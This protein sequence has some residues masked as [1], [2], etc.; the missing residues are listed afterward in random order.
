MGPFQIFPP[1]SPDIETQASRIPIRK[2]KKPAPGVGSSSSISSIPLQEIKSSNE[3][4]TRRVREEDVK[5]QPPRKVHVKSHS[6]S[7]LG[8][9]P[10]P[11]W[12]LRSV[13][14]DD[15]AS[16]SSS[17]LA[18]NSSTQI[19]PA[20]APVPS[21]SS[22]DIPFIQQPY[23]QQPSTSRLPPFRHKPLPPR[24]LPPRPRPRGLTLSPEPEIDRDLG[25][26]TVPASVMNFPAGIRES[27]EMRDSSTA[28]L[29]ELWDVANG[30]RMEGGLGRFCLRLVRYGY[31]CHCFRMVDTDATRTGI[32]TFTLGNTQH[33]FYTISI[34]TNTNNKP[35]FLSISR[36]NPSNPQINIPIMSLALE[37]HDYQSRNDNPITHLFS[38]LAAM[39]AIEQSA[40]LATQHNL[41]SADALD[42]EGKAL[43][44]AVEMES[45]QLVWVRERAGYELVHPSLMQQQQQQ[46]QQRVQGQG[47]GQGQTALVG[48]AGIALSPAPALSPSPSPS[49]SSTRPNPQNPGPLHITVSTP[50]PDTSTEEHQIGRA[51]V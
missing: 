13:N 17:S 43:R 23:Y 2:G 36:T 14:H 35:T 7:G 51:H 39:L 40:E 45:C 44:R 47:Q 5:I 9:Q 48:A 25:P 12:T 1:P 19:P 38:H 41:S 29:R 31:N 22:P 37:S 6:E 24:P 18:N 27:V 30:Q 20:P 21:S 34:T 28:E 4:D 8:S 50:S 32:S 10:K 26:K 46:Q 16:S 42:A 15:R 49:P 3:M 11:A 33:P